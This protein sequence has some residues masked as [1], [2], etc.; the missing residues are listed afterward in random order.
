MAGM[1]IAGAFGA[2]LTVF[3][4][5]WWAERLSIWLIFGGIGIYFATVVSLQI[6]AHGDGSSRFTQ[7]GIILFAS[8]VLVI[9]LVLT[10]GWQYEPRRR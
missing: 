5:W 1:I 4:G 8:M 9:R 3:P 7:M 10:K 6:E 2:L